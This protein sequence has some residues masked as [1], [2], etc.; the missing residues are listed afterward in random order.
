MKLTKIIPLQ[1]HK[2]R[3]IIFLSF[4]TRPFLPV[5]SDTGSTDFCQGS[6]NNFLCQMEKSG[7][8]LSGSGKSQN[9]G[10]NH[11]NARKQDQESLE[12]D[13]EFRPIAPVKLGSRQ[14]T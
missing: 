6:V 10:Q 13:L 4:V 1:L 11:G 8:A 7:S 14:C 12:F 2:L 3:G 9:N 5:F